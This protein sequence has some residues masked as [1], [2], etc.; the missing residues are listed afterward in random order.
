MLQSF[1]IVILTAVILVLM[2]GAFLYIYFHGLRY[3]L[4]QQWQLVLDNLRLR[5]DKIP[6]LIETV[7]I[8]VKGEEKLLSDFAKIRSSSWPM[9]KSGKNKVQKDMAITSNLHAVW[10]LAAKFPELARDTNFLAL[11]T[12]FKEISGEIEKSID[13]YNNE[14][15]KYNK[16]VMFII[17]L[18]FSLLFRFAKEPVF[19]FEA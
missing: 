9:D 5:L 17:F 7:N 2:A 10:S 16:R 19:E 8:F 6:N 11:R 1:I 18:P 12:E 13:I 3:E 14:V 4:S 15:R